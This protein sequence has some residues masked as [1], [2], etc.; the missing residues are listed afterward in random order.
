MCDSIVYGKMPGKG[1]RVWQASQFRFRVVY[2]VPQIRL[3]SIKWRD[4][5]ALVSDDDY[6]Y[7]NELPEL[8]EDEE[9]V[10]VKRWVWMLKRRWYWLRQYLGQMFRRCIRRRWG[11]EEMDLVTTVRVVERERVVVEETRRGVFS[12]YGERRVRRRSAFKERLLPTNSGFNSG[13]ASWVTFCRTVQPHCRES[14]TYD[15]VEGDADRCPP[16]L[17]VV[18]M[19]ISLRDVIVMAFKVGMEVTSA[20]FAVKMISMQG[21]AGTITSAQHPILGS[22]IHF[23]S[24]RTWNGFC[25][26]GADG[27]VEQNWIRRM[28]GLCMV[29][30]RS[31]SER[32]RRYHI[33]TE[34][35]WIRSFGSSSKAV[36]KGD[37]GYIPTS[38][39]RKPREEDKLESSDARGRGYA[40]KGTDLI[41][42]TTRIPS[43][44][45]SRQ[46]QK[47]PVGAID[48][49]GMKGA[50]DGTWSLTQYPE[51]NA[52]FSAGEGGA[53][54]YP[55]L[56]RLGGIGPPGPPRF[57]TYID[58]ED[59]YPRQRRYLGHR[60][61]SSS[62]GNIIT[63]RRRPWYRRI[64]FARLWGFLSRDNDSRSVFS[65]EVD[66]R[67][68]N[69]GSGQST[70]GRIEDNDIPVG[71]IQEN[72][73]TETV[74]PSQLESQMTSVPAHPDTIEDQ[75]KLDKMTA[76]HRT[77]PVVVQ[78]YP[79][80]PTQPPRN[81]GRQPTQRSLNPTVEDAP[82]EPPTQQKQN[83][84][85]GPILDIPVD[86]PASPQRTEP[87]PDLQ[88]Q[89]RRRLAIERQEKLR[90]HRLEEAKDREAVHTATGSHYA[91]LFTS[92]GEPVGSRPQL[93][94]G[95]THT[96]AEE[97]AVRR[98]NVREEERAA[99]DR[100]RASRRHDIRS[101]NLANETE[102]TW[103]W[104]S[105]M[106]I[107]PGYWVTPW[108]GLGCFHANICSGAVAIILESLLGFSNKEHEPYVRYVKPARSNVYRALRRWTRNGHIT[109]PSYAHNA[110]GGVVASVPFSAFKYPEFES[111]MPAID[112]VSSYDHQVS[113]TKQIT[114]RDR[115]NDMC[116][117]MLL[118]SWLSLAGRQKEIIS[119]PSNLLKRTAPLIQ[120]LIDDFQLEFE[121]LEWGRNEGGLQQIQ[122]VAASFMDA[123]SD[124]MLS[125]VEQIFLLVAML[126][127]AKVGFCISNGKDSRIIDDFLKNDAQVYLA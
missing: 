101:Q 49:S 60:R 47:I 105:Q 69:G 116:E 2:S 120:Y 9:V 13:E 27:R 28:E 94:I 66:S 81:L 76:P 4:R 29:A 58:N 79:E 97:E 100:A 103:F 31:F 22:L 23:S 5:P 118:D 18:P 113:R 74:S 54:V 55:G 73:T 82:P 126:R 93:L 24:N 75:E 99:R 38:H 121:A 123:L 78:D 15:M 42:T 12:R 48:I 65:S 68:S 89:E 106:D 90:A 59:P 19:Q 45:P 95:W 112:L 37:A 108:F 83:E 62:D 26:L 127:A 53:V 43:R 25:P 63:I 77:S 56:P 67:V 14:M 46:G 98:Q 80:D 87:E 102:V 8:G 91:N 122:A 125:E 1:H 64:N 70:T 51:P 111:P 21:N 110:R 114:D 7:L 17:P 16:D 52:P 36:A 35:N 34:G 92:N 41:D 124:E 10:L 33:D 85:D 57:L 20:A 50:H 32:D 115:D 61:T 109:W 40:L 72:K 11:N 39:S 71:G 6:Y 84:P 86:N 30:G 104:A 3:H 88:F 107:F 96:S 117:L 44:Q 119:G